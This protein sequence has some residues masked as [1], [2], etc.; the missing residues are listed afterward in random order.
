MAMGW[1]TDRWLV[2]WASDRWLTQLSGRCTHRMCV[3]CKQAESEGNEFDVVRHVDI[4]ISWEE[5][6]KQHKAAHSNKKAQHLTKDEVLQVAQASKPRM[7]RKPSG[8]RAPG[9]RGPPMGVG[10][11]TE[12]AQ[13]AATAGTGPQRRRVWAWAAGVSRWVDI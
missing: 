10:V 11:A 4:D 8:R 1:A 2:E 9:A 3:A 6:C 12:G 13:P 7:A 5:Y